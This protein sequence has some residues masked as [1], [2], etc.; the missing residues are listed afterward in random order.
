[1]FQPRWHHD[2]RLPGGDGAGA[3]RRGLQRRSAA[4]AHHAA[5]DQ[6]AGCAHAAG[7]QQPSQKVCTTLILRGEAVTERSKFGD[8]KF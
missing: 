2:L 4:L 3:I 5:E 8:F 6:G 7:G 1:M